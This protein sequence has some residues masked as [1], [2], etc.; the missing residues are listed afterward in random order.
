MG[1]RPGDGDASTYAADWPAS[2]EGRPRRKAVCD[3]RSSARHRRE[4]RATPQSM[5]RKI[6]GKHRPSGCWSTC[7]VAGVRPTGVLRAPDW[8]EAPPGAPLLRLEQALEVA[9]APGKW[10]CTLCGGLR[11]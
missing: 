11:S 1:G 5:V 2:P 10:L 6:L 7:A 4:D 8:E 9:E 3:G